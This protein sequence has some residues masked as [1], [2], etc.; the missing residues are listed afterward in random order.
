MTLNEFA[1][2]TVPPSRF[3]TVTL[4]D[5]VAALAATVTFS[6]AEVGVT[7][8]TVALTPV[9]EKVTTRPGCRPV[10]DSCTV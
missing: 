1:L 4:R 7:L 10:P 8:T 9:P 3:E 2:V 5:P 6:V